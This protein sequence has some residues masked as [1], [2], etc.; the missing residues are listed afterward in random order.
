MAM[1]YLY[2]CLAIVFE[3]GWAI[4]M[5]MSG[6]L[7][8]PW[9]TAATVVMYALSLV[10]LALATRKLE[11]GTAY[12]I[13]AGA[14]VSIIA[15]AGIVWFNEP[16]NTP[17]IVSLLLIVAGIAG[18]QFWQTPHAPS[19]PTITPASSDQPEI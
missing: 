19:A 4:A 18:L 14:G 17:K 11:I 1:N 6:G 12:A 8:R 15:A 10:F 7:S 2:L 9:P 16:I 5:K 13:W 3:A